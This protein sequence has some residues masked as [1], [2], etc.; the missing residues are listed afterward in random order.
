VKSINGDGIL[1]SEEKQTKLI[2]ECLKTIKNRKR[3][4]ENQ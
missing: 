3:E 4:K 2:G 1:F